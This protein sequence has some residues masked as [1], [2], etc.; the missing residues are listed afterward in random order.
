VSTAESGM[1]P[2][3]FRRQVFIASMRMAGKSHLP[4]SKIRRR[5]LETISKCIASSPEGFESTSPPRQ[6]FASHWLNR[7]SQIIT[8]FSLSQSCAIF[9]NKAVFIVTT[10][11]SHIGVFTFG[12]KGLAHS[13]KI[14][15]DSYISKGQIHV[16]ETNPYLTWRYCHTSGSFKLHVTKAIVLYYKK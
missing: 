4:P 13:S 8:K 7:T 11:T 6:E 16:P 15:C 14:N 1:T 5:V 9:W 10:W 3:K 2:L 12:T